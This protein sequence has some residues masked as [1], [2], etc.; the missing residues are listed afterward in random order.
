VVLGRKNGAPT[1]IAFLFTGQGSQRP[2]MCGDLYPKHPAFAAALDEVCRHLDPR[3]PR[4]LKDVLFADADSADAALLDRTVFTQAA[5][6]AVELA[7]Y[8][9][10]EHYGVTPDYLLGHSVGELTAAC[11]AGVLDLPDACALV[12]ERG[13][14]MQAAR[15]GGAM[16]AVEAAEADVRDRLAP[17][18]D[19]LGVAAVNGPRAVVISGDADAAD[20]IAAAWR[21]EG[22]RTTRLPVSHA[23]HSS[24]MDDVL[25]EFRT[26]VEGLTLHA[27]RI[28]V[29]SNLTGAVATAA[30]LTSAEYWVRHIREAVRFADGVRCLA[31]EGVTDYVEL[32]PDAVLTSLARHCLTEEQAGEL[33]PTL[34]RNRPAEESVARAVAL[35][36]L[37]GVAVDWHAVLPGARQVPLPTYAFQRERYWL[38]APEG[39]VDAS[40]LGMVGTG[41]PLLGAMVSMA[42]R[43]VH[44]FSG[45][46]S[47]HTHPWLAEHTVAGTLLVPAAAI[48]ELTVHAGGHVGTPT[49]AE[50]TVSAPLVLPTARGA[51]ALQLTIGE[52]DESGR[53]GF[54][55]HARAEDD[56]AVDGPWTAHAEGTLAAASADPGTGLP[57]W[58]PIGAAEVAVADFYDTLADAGYGYGPA[59]R[60]LR[61][62][63][64]GQDELFAEVAL[65]EPLRPEARRH[66]LHPALLDAALHPLLLDA[67]DTGT[68]LVPF[69]WTGV[70]LHS[71]GAA[72]LRVRLR[73]TGQHTAALTLADG[74]GAPVATV[75][76][77][78]LRPLERQAGPG[79]FRV[80]WTP[81]SPADGAGR[82]GAEDLAV[83]GELSADHGTRYDTPAE[84]FTAI[85]AGV[86][87]P[88]TVVLAAVTRPD[89]RDLPTAARSVLERTLSTAQRWL[90]DDRFTA[91]TLLVATR[92]AVA[93]ADEGIADLAAAGVWGLVRT[94]Q[95]EN[96][97]RI[98]LADLDTSTLPVWLTTVGEPQ[99]AVREN[100]TLVPRLAPASPP[101]RAPEPIRWDRGTIL[102]TGATGALGRLLA[103]HLVTE[104]R[105]SRLLLVS[106]RGADAPGARQFAR[107]LTELGVDVTFAACDT[108][109]R[110]AL[111]AV[112]TAIPDEHP[113]TAVVHAAGVVDDAVFA[114]LTPDRLAAILAAKLD[115]AWHL[116]ELTRTLNPAAFVL[117]SSVAGLL[118][119][120][121]QSGYA[122]ANT[123]LD[124]LAAHRAALGLPAQSLAWGLWEH[125]S[126][127]SA[128]LAEK[129]LLRLAR[130][131][132]LPLSTTDAFGLFDSAPATGEAVLAVT[133][134]DADGLR[135]AGDAVP[136]L[137]HDL[138]PKPAR[139]PA[140]PSG[141]DDGAALTIRLAALP[142]TERDRVLTD[143]VRGHV[144]AV[145]GHGDP[146]EVGTDRPFQDVGFDSLTALELRNALNRD[147]GLRLPASLV[148]D[149][150]TP[151]A[152]VRHVLELIT[153]EQPAAGALVAGQLGRLAAE[154]RRAAVDPAAFALITEE[155]HALLEAAAAAAGALVDGDEAP[156]D[157]ASDEELFAL[158]N[159]FD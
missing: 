157:A 63:W 26:V 69:A 146:A 141:P 38:Q 46:L 155:L 120:A 70:H 83:I 102:I 116:H 17:Y 14:L 124:A 64:R 9:L 110:D 121:G 15:A 145:L 143:L 139:R 22:V 33:V 37:R 122:A 109:D 31:E 29:V 52:P 136:P 27:P 128:H 91:S 58:P 78:L 127:L 137:L 126:A 40:G 13:R 62:V 134:L 85:D 144:A 130:N 10:F 92:G 118:G 12:A 44:V 36:R 57:V 106:R 16:V 74:T 71:Q 95:T 2:G 24:H 101:T 100:R 11:V 43:D 131:G 54:T 89:E 72:V 129:D 93:T 73:V 114:D 158:I 86:P 107:E 59:F 45:R 8:R 20:E 90:A 6:F 56:A 61:R 103:R 148:F 156:V 39:A 5:L 42:D 104:H 79:L 19:R 111:A 154:V 99:F 150:P 98:V 68:P 113:L 1:K 159:N 84:F 48:A 34:R 149:H 76:S 41:H 47:A 138:A 105:A 88:A 152:V 140:A 147:T 96:P 77:L 132:L 51:V 82:D 23:F 60:G 67:L 80:A 4:P 32:G 81:L 53:R 18:G 7:L 112:L 119:T 55:L 117:Y 87:V 50:L 142:E 3:L 28:P 66:T 94:A 97:G 153:V 115:A 75:E 35:L 123:F 25:A 49:I 135:A 21:A 133:R 65:P 30:E 125:T 108:S 151:A